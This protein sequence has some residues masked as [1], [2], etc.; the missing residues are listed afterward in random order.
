MHTP[1]NQGLVGLKQI[2]DYYTNSKT[3]LV[4]YHYVLQN[5]KGFSI[6]FLRRGST[7]KL[8]VYDQIYSVMID[9]TSIEEDEP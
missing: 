7:W 5:A 1:L 2:K 3:C 8:I 9:W 6:N 4:A